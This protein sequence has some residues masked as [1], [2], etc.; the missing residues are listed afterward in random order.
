VVVVG[1]AEKGVEE[2]ETRSGKIVRR[3]LRK[4]ASRQEKDVQD[5]STLVNPECVTVLIE[6]RD[7]WI[8]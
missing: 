5:I 2:E 6:E 8:K 4:V 7:R 1:L 3:I